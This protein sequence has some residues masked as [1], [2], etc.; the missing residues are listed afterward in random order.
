MGRPAERKNLI[1]EELR[2]RIVAGELNPGSR[3]PTRSEIE[4]QYG[5][6]PTTVQRALESLRRDGFIRVHS[7]KGTFVADNPPH[8]S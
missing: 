6:G 7:R 4:K 3:F 8:L 2:S 5:A 1:V